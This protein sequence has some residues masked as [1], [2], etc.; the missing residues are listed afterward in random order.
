[1]KIECGL[2]VNCSE[3][4]MR[5]ALGGQNEE[6][7]EQLKDKLSIEFG[8]CYIRPED[9]Q[10]DDEEK[11]K[12]YDLSEGYVNDKTIFGVRVLEINGD[13]PYNFGDQL[14]EIVERYLQN[15]KVEWRE[16]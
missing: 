4:T 2:Q 3:A 1:M 15:A 16:E 10:W 8:D 7:I 14:Q 9:K 11:V 12:E 13:A 6:K 5:I